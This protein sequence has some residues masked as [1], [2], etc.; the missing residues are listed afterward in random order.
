MTISP[1]NHE[2]EKQPQLTRYLDGQNSPEEEVKLKDGF[3]R[4]RQALTSLSLSPQEKTQ[5]QIRMYHKMFNEGGNIESLVRVTAQINHH[6][7]S[8]ATL[9]REYLDLK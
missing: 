5:F 4:F 9:L 7:N 1:S 2:K 6:S 3:T 8:I